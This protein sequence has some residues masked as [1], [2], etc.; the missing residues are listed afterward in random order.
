MGSVL[1]DDRMFLTEIEKQF[2]TANL[3]Y[4]KISTI[5]RKRKPSLK[6]RNDTELLYN[7]RPP[8]R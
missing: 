2:G 4:Q 1:I 5:L 6:A 8:L 7:I 3:T